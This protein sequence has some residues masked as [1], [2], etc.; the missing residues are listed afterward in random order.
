[1]AEALAIASGIAALL[2][3]VASITTTSHKYFHHVRQTPVEIRTYFSEL[4]ALNNILIELDRLVTTTKYLASWT[5]RGTLTNISNAIADCRQ[6]LE[7][8]RKKLAPRVIGTSKVRAVWNRLTWPLC[9]GETQK[10]VERLHRYQVIFLA[11][12]SIQGFVTQL[13]MLDKV[14]SWD[15]PIKEAHRKEVLQWL[16]VVDP[17]TNHNAACA[18]HEPSTGDWFTN[19]QDFIRWWA[20][21]SRILLLVGIPGCGKTVLC[22]TTIESVKA[23]STRCNNVGFAYFYFDFNDQQK[24]TIDGVLRSILKQLSSQKDS[25]LE[26]VHELHE[27]CDTTSPQPATAAVVEALLTIAKRFQDVYIVVDALDE[28]QDSSDFTPLRDLEASFRGQRYHCVSLHNA[29]IDKDITLHIK[30]QLRHNDQLRAWPQLVRLEIET[31]LVEGFA[32]LRNSLSSLPKTLDDT[33]CPI[34]LGIDEDYRQEAYTALQWLA[35]ALRPLR[36]NEVAEA[37]VVRPGCI[38]LCKEERLRDPHDLLAICSSLVMLSEDGYLQFSH[39]SV[40]E[41]LVSERIRRSSASLFAME[42][43]LAHKAMAEICL[44]YLLLFI[45]SQTFF[46][47]HQYSIRYWYRHAQEVQPGVARTETDALALQLMRSE[48]FTGFRSRFDAVLSSDQCGPVPFFKR[49][50]AK[51]GSPLYYASYCGLLNVARQLIDFGEDVNACTGSDDSPLNAAA[52]VGDIAMVKLLMERGASIDGRYTASEEMSVD[53]HEREESQLQGHSFLAGSRDQSR[54]TETGWQDLSR[55]R[56]TSGG[57]LA[58]RDDVLFD[59]YVPVEL[60]PTLALANGFASGG[61]NTEIQRNLQK[62][63][64]VGQQDMY[65]KLML[66]PGSMLDNIDHQYSSSYFDSFKETVQSQQRLD[67]IKLLI[68]DRKGKQNR[69]TALHRAAWSGHVEIVRYLIGKGA[70]MEAQDAWDTTALHGAAWRGHL[71]VMK[72]LLE[73]GASTNVQDFAGGAALHFAAHA[74]QEKAIRLLLDHSANINARARFRYTGIRSTKPRCTS[75]R[76]P[77]HEAAWMGR[78]G[79]IRLLVDNGADVGSLDDN[80]QMALHKADTRGFRETV[81][82]LSQLRPRGGQLQSPESTQ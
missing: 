15:K 23:L 1:M 48:R 13:D 18:K 3:L 60:T 7:D 30:N 24:Q 20:G 36:V 17:S 79:V 46:P 44:T 64:S 82:L 16:C 45:D 9:M 61:D 76:T 81:D 38:S 62:A 12:L 10:L 11:P 33:Y 47:L 41:F 32:R 35:F 63:T 51:A 66:D 28:C 75:G 27:Q 55:K 54:Q 22:S 80:G 52:H 71:E 31:A 14:Q 25:L 5:Q 49:P 6:V 78:N 40:K 19:S 58:G 57:K 73:K 59:L 42:D 70:D 65:E 39:Y 77:L 34:L 26:Q 74:G 8:L 37:I 29:P 43:G 72:I 50:Y 2:S 4:S 69:K 53:V 68:K 67:A 56:L 21:I